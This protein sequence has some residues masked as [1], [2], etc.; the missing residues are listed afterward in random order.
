MNELNLSIRLLE[1]TDI[2]VIA[3]AFVELGWNKPVTQYERYLREQKYEV[4]D[5]YVAFVEVNLQI[6]NDLWKRL[7]RFANEHPELVDFNVL[8]NFRRMGSL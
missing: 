5:V 2:A 6:S 1:E 3:Q 8:P 7:G 4:R